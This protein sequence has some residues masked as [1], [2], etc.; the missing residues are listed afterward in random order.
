M[1]FTDP[2]KMTILVHE[3][4]W[5]KVIKRYYRNFVD[6]LELKGDEKVLDFGCGPGAASKFIALKLAKG[7]GELTCLDISQKWIE[8]AKKNLSRFSNVEYY[9]E[10]IRKW[11]EK[12]EFYDSVVVHVM[13]HDIAQKERPQVVKA[14]SQKMK[15]GARLIIREPTKEG[16]GICPEEI[17]ELME[18]NYLKEEKSEIVKRGLL[19]TMYAGH[20]RKAS[21]N[22]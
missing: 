20:Y 15:R 4:F 11:D 10:D 9:V 21:E 6:T 22:A 3:F 8:R 17:R 1:S 14:L 19:G 5:F 12:N 18:R 7:G 16:H 13:L 2:T